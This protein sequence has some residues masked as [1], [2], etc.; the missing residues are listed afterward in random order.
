MAFEDILNRILDD[1]KKKAREVEDEAKAEAQRIVEDAKKKAESIKAKL[2]EEAKSR[3]QEEGKRMLS[4]ARLEA[5]Y[6]VLARKRAAL[7]AAFEEALKRL[8]SLPD[9][10]YGKLV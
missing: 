1:A 10:E 9:G 6:L 5:R 2:L 3:T 4:L 7:D 8:T